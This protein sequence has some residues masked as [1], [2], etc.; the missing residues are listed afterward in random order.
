M[1]KGPQAQYFEALAQGRFQIQRCDACRAPNFYPRNICPRCG[2]DRLT[3]FEP[4]GRGTVY[5]TTTVRRSAEDGG[6][7]NVVLVDLEEGVRMMSSIIGVAPEDV[8]IGQDVVFHSID[9]KTRDAVY[10]TPAGGGR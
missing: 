3:W 5:S 10:F 8:S 7:Y 4:S 2:S 6:N 1:T 9:E